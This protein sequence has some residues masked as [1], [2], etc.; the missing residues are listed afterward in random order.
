MTW[1][2]CRSA[3]AHGLSIFPKA[4]IP[5][6]RAAAL[7]AL[8]RTFTGGEGSTAAQGT[9]QGGRPLLS[10]CCRDYQIEQENRRNFALPSIKATSWTSSSIRRVTMTAAH[11]CHRG[12]PAR[13]PRSDDGHAGPRARRRQPLRGA[14]GLSAHASGVRRPPALRFA[15]LLKRM[16]KVKA[17]KGY[18]GPVVVCAV[19]FSPVAGYIPTPHCDQI[20]GQ[21]C[22]HR[23]VVGAD[24]RNAGAGA[25]PHE[26]PT[27]IEAGRARSYAVRLDCGFGQGSGENPR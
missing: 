12:E 14:R 20:H 19:Y 6:L 16:D 7:P 11:P 27:P 15:A 26:G 2:V 10:T 13:R 1:P 9:L 25:L 22:G 23:S 3:R 24:R 5:R 17:D 4:R 8:M 21:R 18:E